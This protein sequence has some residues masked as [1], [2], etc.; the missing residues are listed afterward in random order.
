MEKKTQNNRELNSKSTH[1][2]YNRDEYQVE[3]NN[4]V[5]DDVSMN[6]LLYFL[7]IISGFVHFVFSYTYVVFVRLKIQ[8]VFVSIITR[9]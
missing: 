8:L 6:K 2:I 5:K 1:P 3:Y 9:R 7:Y 4:H